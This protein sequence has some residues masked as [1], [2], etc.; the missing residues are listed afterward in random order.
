MPLEGLTPKGPAV[1]CSL[2]AG[3]PL[4]LAAAAA[5]A[6][7]PGPGLTGLGAC[8]LRVQPMTDDDTYVHNAPEQRDEASI[9]L[10]MPWAIAAA[11]SCPMSCATKVPPAEEIAPICVFKGTDHSV[12]QEDVMSHA[13][14]RLDE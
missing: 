5:A 3:L 11:I 2:T 6:A 4:A 12:G 13:A 8:T 1:S 10:Q 14:D 7:A 9:H